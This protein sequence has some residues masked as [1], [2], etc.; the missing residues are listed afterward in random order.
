[1]S[2]A[3]RRFAVHGAGPA[4]RAGAQ[5]PHGARPGRG[6]GLR[7]RRR[8]DQGRRRASP[9]ARAWPS[10]TWWCAR[11]GA[12]TSC[13]RSVRRRGGR[14]TSWCPRWPRAWCPACASPRP[15]AGATGT[16][17]RFSRP[18]RWIVA[19]LDERTVPFE[20]HG[21]T[22]G[23]VSQGHRFL[24]GPATIASAAGYDAAL[25]AVAVI[26]SH[27][28]RRAPIVAGLDAAAAAAGGAWRD[29]G[30][31]LEEVVFLVEWPSVITGRF[32]ERHLR[33]PAAGA[34]DRHAGP[35][36]LLPARGRAGRAA[37]GL[38]AGLQRRPGARRRHHAR[39]RGRARRAPAGRRVQLRQG[40][41]G[42]ARR[43]RRPPRRD[44]VPQA[45]GHHG[46]QAR[47]PAWRGSRTSPP[48]SGPTRRRA[49]AA[50]H[51]ARLRQG[52]PGRR[53]GGRVLRARGLRGRRVR[54]PRGRRRR[55]GRRPSRSSTCPRAP[56][57]RCPPDRGRARW[58][59]RPRRSTTSSARS[60][61]TRR[62]PARRTPTA[63]AAPR[64][65]LVRIALE[66]GWDIDHDPVLEPAYARLTGAGRRPLGG[67]TAT[68]VAAIDAF[69]ADRLVY[70]LGD[71]GRG[72]RG[73]GGRHRRGPGRPRPPPRAWARAIEAARAARRFQ[74]RVD[75]RDP[76]QRIARKGPD[77]DVTPVAPGR[78]SRGGG[79]ARRRSRRPGRRSRRPGGRG[80]LRRALD[81]AGPLAAAVDRFF[82]DVL[83]NADDPGVRAR[84]YGL[85]REAAGAPSRR[86]RLRSGHRCRGGAVSSRA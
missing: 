27:E 75:R 73:R 38:P 30:G 71:R 83:V 23:D 84:R 61:W 55:R 80:D 17:L 86:R 5:R 39:Q 26:P 28:A 67:R 34:G 42:G 19:K 74:R 72:R 48:A 53:A 52:R 9:A 77:E 7:A 57:R 10:R 21:L 49:A 43:P 22:A 82:V 51:A 1:M 50:E 58:W 76:P 12:A 2:V 81:A 6:G 78:R 15:C 54:P 24:G 68:R 25:R 18:V 32:D 56:T 14:W 79:P 65:G 63:C 44:R 13:S 85:V 29:P 36:A 64:L 35:P 45:P 40:P 33:L 16:G 37:A 70:L 31:K 47:P 60:P 41:G 46:R 3:P 59:P 20:L 69:L 62:R 4:G 11:S 66:R 8:A